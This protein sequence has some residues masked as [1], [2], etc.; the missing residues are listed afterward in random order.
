MRKLTNEIYEALRKKLMG[1]I[2]ITDDEGV[3]VTKDLD[4]T[5]DVLNSDIAY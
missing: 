4:L 1:K 2:V 5:Q 3:I